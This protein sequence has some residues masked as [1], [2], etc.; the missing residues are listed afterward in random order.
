MVMEE[1]VR[2]ENADEP[3]VSVDVFMLEFVT[4]TLRYVRYDAI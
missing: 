2:V 4:A 3:A 1:A